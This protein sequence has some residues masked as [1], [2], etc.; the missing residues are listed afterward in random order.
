[1]GKELLPVGFVTSMNEILGDASCDFWDS[2]DS[3]RTHGLRLN[4]LK[5][6]HDADSVKKL[7]RDFQLT[8]VSWCDTGYYYDESV[9]P[10]KHPYHAAG[11]YYIQEPSAMSAVELLNPQPGETILDLA[12]A[13]G[14][15]TSHI[16]SKMMGRGLLVSNEIHPERARILAEN[17]ERMGITNTVVTSAAPDQLSSRF[18]ACFDRIMLDAPCSGEGMF[19]KDAAAIA[20][21][22]PEHVDL[23][24]ARQ[25]DIVQEAYRMLK[26]G[27]TLAYSTCTF[28][29]AENE[30]MIERILSQYPDLELQQMKRL[31]PHL[32]RG[33]GHFVA[34][35]VKTPAAEAYSDDQETFTNSGKAQAKSNRGGKQAP[36][37]SALADFQDWAKQ[38]LPGFELGGGTPILFG[39]ELYWL[40]VSE[41]V[42]WHDKQLKGLKMPRAGLHLAHLKKNRIEPAH[43]LAMSLNSG[44][45]ARSW[46]LPSDSA[47]TAAYLRGEVISIPSEYR[48]WTLV[49]TD[50]LPLGWGKA[51]GGQLKNHLPKGLRNPK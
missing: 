42:P 51:S 50:G 41:S 44:Q 46:D 39:E 16:A 9:R 2:Y 34:I 31:W 23:C 8:P 22:S 5:A 38:D 18:V 25:W 4:R 20:E 35:L 24:V 12:A 14:G 32:E 21:W 1:M 33:E 27:G 47:E 30:E 28:N 43:A 15:K 19:R 29:T 37:L 49:T 45:A 17:V 3:P 26:P 10:G 6:V 40:P 48:G 36:A 7:I 11:L 13:P